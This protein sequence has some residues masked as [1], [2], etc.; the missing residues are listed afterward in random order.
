LAQLSSGKAR[1]LRQTRQANEV[2]AVSMLDVDNAIPFL[3]EH[4]LVE[5]GW[6]VD[7]DLTLR[8]AA[9]RNRNLRIEGPGGA[10]YLI[11]Q[12]DE[13]APASRRTLT[14]E[15]AFYEFCQQEAA[16]AP[17]ARFLPR[18]VLRDRDRTLHALEL[19]KGAS[20]LASYHRAR[21]PGDFPVAASE[22][23]G[24]GLGTL[25]RVFRL[26]GL[27]ADPR[28]A[29]LSRP[30]PWIFGSQR[31]PTLA[32]LADLSPA[33]SRVFQIIRAEAG[34]GVALDRLGPMWRAET[35]IHGDIKSDN[36]LVG[37]P[38]DGDAAHDAAVWIVDWE[39]VQI[40]DPAWDL[41][42]ALH[43][44]LIFW[45]SSMPLEPHLSVEAMIDQ[46]RYP[47][48]VLRPA[49]RAFW[50]GYLTAAGLDAAG[51]SAEPEADALLHRTVA[52]SAA[53]LILAAH[54]L[55]LEQEELPVQAVLLLQL[56]VNLLA[57]PE[58][59]Q[60]QLYGIPRESGPR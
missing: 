18:L 52:F 20:T 31:R 56:G 34:L 59:G 29:W 21:S 23:L 58:S 60:V 47:L 57:D 12:P 3:L 26:P 2:K 9:R 14:S 53:R 24:I 40:G 43:D 25:H 13:L 55:S 48:G 54:E 38:R 7:G 8:S 22:A 37:T 16:A 27:A 10:G 41:A 19:V 33:G 44:F 50:K 32:M 30:A 15:A 45:T 5:R 51:G 4:G 35:L 46:A 28:L 42:S 6:I 39:F 11:K 17:V 36:I 49:I 1:G